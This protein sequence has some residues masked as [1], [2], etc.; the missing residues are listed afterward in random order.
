MN[1][2]PTMLG[3]VRLLDDC[4]TG[5]GVLKVTSCQ[6]WYI[7]RSKRIKSELK[8]IYC[9]RTGTTVPGCFELRGLSSTEDYS[10]SRKSDWSCI[11]DQSGGN[12]CGVLCSGERRI[13]CPRGLHSIKLLG[14][15]SYTSNRGLS[16]LGKTNGDLKAG[17][18]IQTDFEQSN[19][20]TALCLVFRRQLVCWPVTASSI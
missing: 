8:A 18:N 17:A 9:K 1:T 13:G 5:V 6:V 20:G 7:E 11:E 16:R 14:V 19:L 10:H 15:V 3:K 2:D 4:K 12:L